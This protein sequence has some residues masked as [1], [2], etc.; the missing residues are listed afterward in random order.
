M[1][2][3]RTLT[4]SLYLTL[5]LWAFLLS[6][7]GYLWISLSQEALDYL[8]WEDEKSSKTIASNDYHLLDP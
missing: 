1:P 7:R 2:K 4:I 6:W 3:D 8:T 5:S